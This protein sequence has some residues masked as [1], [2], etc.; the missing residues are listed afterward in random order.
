MGKEGQDKGLRTYCLPYHTVQLRL[1]FKIN[2]SQQL[3]RIL[4][5][6]W[7]LPRQCVALY[8]PPPL[9]S[10]LR[11]CCR[12]MRA[13]STYSLIVSPFFSFFLSFFFFW[14]R[15]K[16]KMVTLPLLWVFL[17]ALS[18][19]SPFTCRF[20]DRTDCG[21]PLKCKGSIGYDACGCCPQCAQLEGQKCGGDWGE[22]GFC[23]PGLRCVHG[24]CSSGEFYR[25]IFSFTI[26]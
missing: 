4:L 17:G 20:C 3:V 23:D 8:P 16:Y 7:L 18:V 2:K 14:F 1:K 12:R 22:L 26:G 10:H 21:A 13:L 11:Q 24:I 6:N 5:L 25:C 19:V 15:Q 9:L